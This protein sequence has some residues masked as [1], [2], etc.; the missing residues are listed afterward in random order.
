M[1]N[2][3]NIIAEI[4]FELSP[5][6][7][8]LLSEK[9]AMLSHASDIEKVKK[10]WGPNVNNELYHR[11]SKA[12]QNK[13]G[14]TGSELGVM[15]QT[16]LAVSQYSE[17][18]GHDELLWTGPKTAVIAVR[19]IEQAFCELIHYAARKLFIV[20]FVAYR[21]ENVLN[22]LDD[23]MKRNVEINFLL[24]QPKE[25]GGT[26]NIDSFRMLKGYLPTANFYIWNDPSKPDS[27]SVHAKCV[28][29]DEHI[30]LISSANLTGKA[31]DD[32]MELGILVKNGH[33]PHQLSSLFEAL[34]FEKTIMLYNQES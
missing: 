32:N 10:F 13:S 11:F 1:D 20:S 6:R 23:A 4:A 18:R 3:F 27:A 28:V 17:K 33:I 34:I 24:E 31:M 7:M 29:A 30:A 8:E 15:F 12:I 5:E 19:Q 2:I 25:H 26:V 14:M 9:M 21:A 22:A 16:A